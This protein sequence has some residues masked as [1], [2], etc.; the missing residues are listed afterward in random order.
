MILHGLWAFQQLMLR[1]S[2]R[3]LMVS[4]GLAYLVAQ[5]IRRKHVASQIPWREQAN[6]E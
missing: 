1:T 4:A 6:N 3:N 5:Q 2:V